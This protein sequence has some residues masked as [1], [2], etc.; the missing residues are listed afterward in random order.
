MV[1]RARHLEPLPGLNARGSCNRELGA[2]HVGRPHLHRHG[3][4]R[5]GNVGKVGDFPHVA[6]QDILPGS[7][8]VGDRAVPM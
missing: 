4:E 8:D 3:R 1:A 2:R 7:G 5:V 6:A